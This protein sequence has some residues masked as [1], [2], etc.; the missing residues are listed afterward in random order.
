MLRKHHG[1]STHETGVLI[2]ST[3]PL[4]PAAAMLQK[5]DV[6]LSVDNIRVANDGTIPFREGAFKERVQVNYY[7]TQR[8]ESD[9]VSLEILRHGERM[10]V[11]A[12]LWVP[13]KLI[14]RTLTQKNYINVSSNE[15]TGSKGSIVG[16]VPSYMMIGG[17]VL[18]ALS[19]EYL[20]AE[21]DPEHMGD[22]EGWADEYKLLSLSDSSQQEVGEEVVILSQV[23]AHTCNIGYELLRNMRLTHFNGAPVKNLRS[24]KTMVDAASNTLKASQ[25]GSARGKANRRAIISALEAPLVFEFSSGQIVVLEASA[26]FAA[27]SQIASE[28][29][30]RAAQSVDLEQ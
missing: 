6:L 7:F 1:M 30:I 25:V 10:V 15:G 28:H 14:P 2:L 9:I 19:K 20:E 23:I 26:A 27:Q 8:F 24:L 11:K 4:A 17:L 12:P 5:N 29:F 18:M 13:K 22:F 3:A 16:G 21:F